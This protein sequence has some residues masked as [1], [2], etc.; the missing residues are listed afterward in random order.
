MFNLLRT[1]NIIHF[2]L[3]KKVILFKLVLLITDATR[4]TVEK[5][6]VAVGEFL[7]P[8]FFSGR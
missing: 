3:L 8:T 4:K 6:M 5:I 1:G 2:C 7:N